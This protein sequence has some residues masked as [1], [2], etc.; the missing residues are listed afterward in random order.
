MIVWLNRVL[1]WCYKLRLE[2]L[3]P[4]RGD[5]TNMTLTAGLAAGE[6]ERNDVSTKMMPGTQAW[7]ASWTSRARQDRVAEPGLESGGVMEFA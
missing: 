6:Y 4:V 2:P 7:T 5:T 3:F 1:E